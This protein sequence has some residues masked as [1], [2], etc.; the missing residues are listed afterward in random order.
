MAATPDQVELAVADPE[1]LLAQLRQ[2]ATVGGRPVAIR[3][4]N[5]EIVIGRP[6]VRLGL[7]VRGQ[8]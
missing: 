2:A 3:L 1:E 4:P 6:V 5:G 8:P 7:P